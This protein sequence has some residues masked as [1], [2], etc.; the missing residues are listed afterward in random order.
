MHLPK[1]QIDLNSNKPPC[2]QP[3]GVACFAAACH[4][5]LT[6]VGWG[7]A[8][9]NMGVWILNTPVSDSH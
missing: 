3:Q 5:L 7:Y 2:S 6:P 4:R 8:V 9:Y 1:L